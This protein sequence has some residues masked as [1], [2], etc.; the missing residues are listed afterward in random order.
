MSEVNV[1]YQNSLKQFLNIFDNSITKST[2]SP[3]TDE[4]I[5]IIL[6]YLTYEVIFDFIYYIF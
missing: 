6:K 5:G 2:K 4:R 1:M 3:N